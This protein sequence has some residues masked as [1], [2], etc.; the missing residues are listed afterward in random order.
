MESDTPTTTSRSGRVV[1]KSIKLLE[2]DETRPA[3]GRTSKAGP[4][5]SP[6]IA[7]NSGLATKDGQPNLKVRLSFQSGDF[8]VQPK[9]KEETINDS[10]GE[11]M[12]RTTINLSGEQGTSGANNGTI[13]VVNNVSSSASPVKV[14][15][16]QTENIPKA[17]VNEPNTIVTNNNCNGQLITTS[18]SNNSKIIVNNHTD[19]PPANKKTKFE[20]VKLERTPSS[21]NNKQKLTILQVP[22]SL[23][24]INSSQASIPPSSL[25]T[26]LP[27]FSSSTLTPTIIKPRSFMVNS[28]SNSFTT[29]LQQQSKTLVPTGAIAR[30]IQ[31]QKRINQANR[32][33]L[34]SMVQ[35][36][37]PPPRHVNYHHPTPTPAPPK[38]IA[39]RRSNNY[40]STGEKK[41]KRPSVSA[42]VLWCK[43]SRRVMHRTYPELDF[44]SLSKKMGEIWHQLPQNEKATWFSKAKMI[45]E[46][47]PSIVND[48]TNECDSIYKLDH[49]DESMIPKVITD[50]ITMP[51]TVDTVNLYEEN[52]SETSDNKD[53]TVKVIY[54]GEQHTIG[55]EFA[56]LEAYFNILGDSL[57]SIGSYL[58]R[59]VR[60]NS[61]I[62]YRPEAAMTTLLDTALVACASLTVLA[63]KVPDLQMDQN[64]MKQL[65]DGVSY[66]MPPNDLS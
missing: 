40:S 9:F 52:F 18:A 45:A 30:S 58:K 35:P 65:M 3:T 6:L 15:N 24:L 22:K 14:V 27:P 29:T 63:N 55:L 44:A 53:G 47:G 23:Q 62:E 46:H 57:M 19:S 10:I 16:I 61:D 7:P 5:A 56:D 25:V 12:G 51:I 42:Y 43:D 2:M 60:Y 28:G 4:I 1:K 33:R 17:N 36:T 48:P 11:S 8:K 39:K 20:V 41:D 64:K 31:E 34:V 26:T 59:G 38:A 54:E 49:L 50:R 66:F 37:P 32:A 21:I 13:Q